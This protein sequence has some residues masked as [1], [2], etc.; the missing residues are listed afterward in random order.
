MMSPLDPKRDLRLS[1]QV[2]YT[3]KSS[4][5]VVLKMEFIGGGGKKDDTVMI[6]TCL[7]HQCFAKVD[8]V[9]R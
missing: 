7:D 1:G 9:F 8:L 2:I 4:M 3:G 5:E 6:G